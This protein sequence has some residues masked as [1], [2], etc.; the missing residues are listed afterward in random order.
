MA[1]N[2]TTAKCGQIHV[3]EGKSERGK[4]A[5]GRMEGRGKYVG[6][7]DHQDF[8]DCSELSELVKVNSYR[9]K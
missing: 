3:R 2:L 1:W 7:L 8:G 6:N 5:G 9:Q 4:E